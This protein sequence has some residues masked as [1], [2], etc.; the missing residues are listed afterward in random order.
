MRC[1]PPRTAAR[2]GATRGAPRLSS[3]PPPEERSG[4]RGGWHPVAA[5]RGTRSGSWQVCQGRCLPSSPPWTPC[6]TLRRGRRGR[7]SAGRR[8]P[9]MKMWPSAAAAPARWVPCPTPRSKAPVLWPSGRARPP[10]PSRA[11][12]CGKAAPTHGPATV[13]SRTQNGPSQWAVAGQQSR[14]AD[15]STRLPS[16]QRATRCS[17]TRPAGMGQTAPATRRIPSHPA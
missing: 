17:Y 5:P 13:P 4:G 10:W 9:L 3:C 15:R 2:P 14:P 16:R 6:V 12:G 11:A 7:P 1:Q 8:R